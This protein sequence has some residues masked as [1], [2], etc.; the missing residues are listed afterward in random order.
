[1]ST[2]EATL[3]P[4]EGGGRIDGRPFLNKKRLWV[5]GGLSL[6]LLLV[7]ILL[8]LLFP[9]IPEA[10]LVN[11]N[12]PLIPST[13]AVAP[14]SIN[15]PG[16]SV[17]AAA[18]PGVDHDGDLKSV[19]PAAVAKKVVSVPAAVAGKPLSHPRIPAAMQQTSKV[20]EKT[21][22]R[23]MELSTFNQG[24][25]A[26]ENGDYPEAVLNFNRSLSVNPLNVRTYNG[27]G[28]ALMAMGEGETAEEAFRKGLV[29]EPANVRCLNNLA[30]LY[31]KREKPERAIPFLEKIIAD[32][33]EDAAAWTNL[34]VAEGRAGKPAAA[35][36]AYRRALQLTPQD[37]RIHFNLARTLEAQGRDIEAIYSYRAFLRLL[38]PGEA[39]RA[40]QVAAHL[41]ELRKSILATAVRP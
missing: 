37:Y 32:H 33:P 7:V 41:Q 3:I 34:G 19:S 38:P 9:P 8:K 23:L 35:E 25:D 26:L 30:L 39:D 6:L 18:R 12:R 24:V 4:Q 5:Y 11:L 20:S 27:L 15:V 1:M 17:S 31:I 28:L 29:I 2:E 36:N 16:P 13:P 10:T 21:S 40:R 22:R 14:E